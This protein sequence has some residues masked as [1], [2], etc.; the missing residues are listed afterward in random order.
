MAI[1]TQI[2]TSK[3]L[4]GVVMQTITSAD[5]A[6]FD[7]NE[8]ARSNRKTLVDG[9]TTIVEEF[10]LEQG[11]PQFAFDATVSTDPLETHE[12]F[13]TISGGIPTSIRNKW[14][15]WKKNPSDPGL[16][17]WKPEEET[18]EIFAEFYGLF[19]NGFEVYYTPRLTAR[20][21]VLEE[22]AP[23]LSLL[24]KIDTWGGGW[25]HGLTLPTGAD[26][27]LSGVRSQQEG[28]FFRNTY[29]YMSSGPGGWNDTIYNPTE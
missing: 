22:G 2:E 13:T 21:T 27:I 4:Q 11:Q 8:N 6:D 19:R 17:G 25:P 18:N 7:P 15:L 14:L 29:E 24:G 20:V 28:A 26:F 10:L 23:N 16:D 9:V 1:N 3:D 5:I 12:R